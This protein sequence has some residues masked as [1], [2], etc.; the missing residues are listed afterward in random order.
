MQGLVLKSTGSFYRIA[1]ADSGRV[2]RCRVKGKMRTLLNV[3]TNPIA[4]GD[5]VIFE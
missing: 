3:T 5:K 1:E 4:V 2:F